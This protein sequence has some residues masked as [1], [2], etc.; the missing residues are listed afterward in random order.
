MKT[1]LVA[2][3]LVA[4][5]GLAHTMGTMI[6]AT[7]PY[8]YNCSVF[9]SGKPAERAAALAFAQGYVAA[10]NMD[11]KLDVDDQVDLRN[12]WREL[13]AFVVRYCTDK[14]NEYLYR[15]F[16]NDA[17]YDALEDMRKSGQKR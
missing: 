1:L 9:V 10:M 16:V 2:T 14:S 5:T 11:P 17:A 4:L 3:F 6:R 7:G 15:R 13:N 8:N 12:R